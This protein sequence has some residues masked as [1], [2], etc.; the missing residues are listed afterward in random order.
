M[1]G[2]DEYKINYKMTTQG[3][4]ELLHTL[5]AA[6]GELTGGHPIMKN[7]SLKKTARESGFR[8]GSQRDGFRHL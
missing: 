8:H 5:L 7:P 4:Q 6:V 1:K 3:S 2:N